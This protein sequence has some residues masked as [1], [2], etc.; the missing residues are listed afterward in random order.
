MRL[1]RAPRRGLSLVEVI[2]SLAIFLFSLIAIGQLLNFAGSLAAEAR[3]RGTA[4][5]LAQSKLAEVVAGAVALQGAS[6]TCEDEPDYEWQVAAEP[7]A[8]DMLHNVTVTVSRKDAD[9][10]V[11]SVSLSQMV[12]DPQRVGNLN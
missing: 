1:R 10:H 7:G 6:G 5:R 4:A 11:V 9:G 2:A 8:S 3:T 12:L